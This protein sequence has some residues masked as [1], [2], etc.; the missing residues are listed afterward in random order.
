ME[1]RH[2]RQREA[3][4]QAVCASHDHPTA[5]MVYQQLKPLLPKLSLGTVYRNLRQLAQEGRI[6]ELPGPVA[7]FDGILAPHNHMQC[8]RCGKTVDFG[9]L[10][11]DDS[12]DHQRGIN[13]WTVTGHTLV[14]TGLCP[15]CQRQGLKI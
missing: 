15:D 11:Y 6:R 9:E 3:I 2:S 13:G 7:R 1:Q 8:L 14:F 5:E 12:L 10:P 4:Y